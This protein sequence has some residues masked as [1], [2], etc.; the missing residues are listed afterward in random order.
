MVLYKTGKYIDLASHHVVDH[1]ATVLHSNSYYTVITG[2]YV[3]VPLEICSAI[4]LAMINATRAHLPFTWA[5]V[6]I[7]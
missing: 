5:R 1:S 3:G 6:H 7:I 2:K 4:L